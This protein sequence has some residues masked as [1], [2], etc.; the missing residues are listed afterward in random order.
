[1]YGSFRFDPNPLVQAHAREASRAH[2]RKTRGES[3]WKR[4]RTQNPLPARTPAAAACSSPPPPPPSSSL[5]TRA[6]RRL[7][8]PP[9]LPPRSASSLALERHAYKLSSRGRP[10]RPSG[11][12]AG[13]AG[14]R[15]LAPR[16]S[17]ARPRGRLLPP[18]VH[19]RGGSGHRRRLAGP[20]PALAEVQGGRGSPPSAASS[21]PPL[22]PCGPAAVAPDRVLTTSALLATTSPRCTSLN[23]RYTFARKCMIDLLCIFYLSG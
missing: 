2:L 22:P 12:A 11:P 1:M 19:P 3:G 8:P 21:P 9:P 6:T 13:R 14:A 18:A 4:Q 7:P 17:T 16:S 20:R 15:Q 10:H 5:S 23:T